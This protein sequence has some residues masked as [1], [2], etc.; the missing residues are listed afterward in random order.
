MRRTNNPFRD[1]SI[2]Y[3]GAMYGNGVIKE[4]AFFE[5]GSHESHSIPRN[6]RID[7]L[8]RII[9]EGYDMHKVVRGYLIDKVALKDYG[10]ISAIACTL[11]SYADIVTKTL[12]PFEE[13]IKRYNLPDENKSEYEELREAIDEL[14]EAVK[15]NYTEKDFVMPEKTK[16]YTIRKLL[17]AYMKDDKREYKVISAALQIDLEED[18]WDK[19]VLKDEKTIP[20]SSYYQSVFKGYREDLLRRLNDD[21]LFTIS[22]IVDVLQFFP[23]DYVNILEQYY[24]KRDY[25]KLENDADLKIKRMLGFA[26]RLVSILW[27]NCIAY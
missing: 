10:R 20:E 19:M 8:A 15:Q 18:I 6:V 16:R 17:L 4:K 21:K 23:K 7:I 1:L 27:L 26:E 25:E 12:R 14:V 9:F 22:Y 5:G 2:T 24:P 3:P 11:K 13:Q